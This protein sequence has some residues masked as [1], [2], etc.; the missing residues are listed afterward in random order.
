M[1]EFRRKFPLESDG[2]DR[3][4]IAW[5]GTF[6]YPE[7]EIRVCLDGSLL[8]AIPDRVALRA[9][10]NFT[11]PDGQHL[12]V[13]LQGNSLVAMLGSTSLGD[14]EHP[15]KE[16]R[17]AAKLYAG[18]AVL[19]LLLLLTRWVFGQSAT[20][21]T[22]WAVAG[23][24]LLAGLYA[25]LYWQARQVRWLAFLAGGMLVLPNASLLF[26]LQ[27]GGL[28]L[29]LISLVVGLRSLDAARTARGLSRQ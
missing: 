19:D 7:S 28:G 3:L 11:L 12:Q 2:P 6:F 21:F 8:G 29:L 14:L 1:P 16:L 22:P 10:Q 20:Q 27:E 23:V 18:V 9:G 4:E 25:L 5:K 13:S 24:L 15:R 26:L 17:Q